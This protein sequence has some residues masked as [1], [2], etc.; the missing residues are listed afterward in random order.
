MPAPPG[1]SSGAGGD[2][3]EQG[4]EVPIVLFWEGEDLIDG[5]N[6]PSKDKL[7]H[8]PG[9]VGFADIFEGDWILLCSVILSVFSI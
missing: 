1:A 9:R 2:G 8:A 5:V 3:F 6:R 4:L 7:L